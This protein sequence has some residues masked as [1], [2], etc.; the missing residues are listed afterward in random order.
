MK[1]PD[2]RSPFI[3]LLCGAIILAISMGI[4]HGFGL[5]LQPMT[6]DL[7]WG[8]ESYALAMAIQNLVWGLSQPV[9]GRFVDR[10]GGGRVAFFG[11][12]LYVAGLYLMSRTG[13]ETE[14]IIGAGILI[15][16]GLSGT[17]FPVVFSAISRVVPPEK[18]SWAMGVSTAM[19]SLGQF[20]FLP[21]SNA[22]LQQFGW[23]S[24]LLILTAISALMIPL[25][26]SMRADSHH[27]QSHIS[28]PLGAILSEAARHRDFWLLALGYF[29]C[30]FQVVF[31][32]VHLPAYLTDAGLTPGTGAV[33]LGLVGLFNV[34]GSYLAGL[35]GGR[36]SKPWLLTGIY[37]GRLVIIAI[38]LLLPVTTWSAYAFGMAMGL[39]WLSTVP[40]TNGIVATVFGVENMSMLGGIV[41]LFHQLG[42]FLGGWL[43]GY[44]YDL[45]GNY[46]LVWALCMALSVMAAL[47]NLPIRERPV[48]R[49]AAE[50]A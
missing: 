5:F 29:V 21:G 4:R 33:V 44:V 19:G 16:L 48:A 32:G 31:I 17:T 10:Y 7:G 28:L 6:D 42:S 43:G 49:L 37:S 50:A 18:R 39:L 45:S 20:L 30:G 35:W 41:F 22:L 15:G 8:R 13:S 26:I 1:S 27:A 11:S 36:V 3:I 14:L 9:A 40:L 38:F 23:S 47:L 12:L 25:A 24:A 2:W 46:N 34:F